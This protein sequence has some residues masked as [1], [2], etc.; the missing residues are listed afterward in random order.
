MHNDQEPA[1]EEQEEPQDGRQGEEEE[2]PSDGP[3][4]LDIVCVLLSTVVK[5][6]SSSFDSG[7]FPVADHH[8]HVFS[9]SVA[10]GAGSL[11]SGSPVDRP[12]PEFELEVSTGEEGFDDS[13]Q[14]LSDVLKQRTEEVNDITISQFVLKFGLNRGKPPVLLSCAGSTFS[15]STRLE[16]FV[17]SIHMITL[18]YSLEASVMPI[19]AECITR[20]RYCLAGSQS[21]ERSKI[22]TFHIRKLVETLGLPDSALHYIKRRIM[23]M[24][25]SLMMG[26]VPVCASCFKYYNTEDS[27][28]R[29]S[30]ESDKTRQSASLAAQRYIRKRPM[31]RPATSTFA[32][33]NPPSLS[34]V[35]VVRGHLPDYRVGLITPSGLRITQDRSTVQ[36]EVA[37]RVY[38]NPPFI[39][40]SPVFVGPLASAGSG[41]RKNG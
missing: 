1:R 6:V 29:P 13:L 11:A 15:P 28:K 32:G 24:C 17:G 33:A 20:G 3:A 22:V 19:T 8:G 39:R 5:P 26:N 34:K 30:T 27:Q 4:C 12:K 23:N 31:Q 37:K 38:R 21:L 14:Q 41:R 16:R 35:P 18:V 25:P 40:P 7:P 36:Y 2:R 10:S 9:V